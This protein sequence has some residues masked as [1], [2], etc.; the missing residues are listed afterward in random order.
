MSGPFRN[1]RPPAVA[2]AFYP[3]D[4]RELADMID[5]QLAYARTLLGNKNGRRRDGMIDAQLVYARTLPGNRSGDRP[6]GMGE[7]GKAEAS[8]CSRPMC[9][10]CGTTAPPPERSARLWPK[11]I[12]VPHAGYVYSGTTAALAYALLAPGRGTIRRAVI[13]G[14]THRVA[15]R[16]VACATYDDLVVL[17]TIVDISAR[18]ISNKVSFKFKNRS[19]EKISRALRDVVQDMQKQ[20]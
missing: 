8:Q 14:P 3:A 5:A 6:D 18:L 16:G 19:I 11:A 15:V 1:L 2:G 10:T 12:I 13:V 20:R 7:A 4:P 17:D 9:G